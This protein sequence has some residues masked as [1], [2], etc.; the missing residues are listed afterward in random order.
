[1][2]FKMGFSFLKSKAIVMKDSEY[3][4]EQITN[5]VFLFFQ[6]M[7]PKDVELARVNFVK[8][9]GQFD[10]EHEYFELKLDDF[11]N[12]F[13]FFYGD[14]QFTNLKKIKKEKRF[15]KYYDYLLSGIFSIFLVQNIKGEEVTLK[16]IASNI[17]YKVKN[18]AVALSMEQGSCIQTSLY[19]QSGGLYEFGL[20][21]LVH[22]IRSLKYIKKKLKK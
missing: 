13:L 16:D 11:R 1:M 2:G 18:A 8:L 5:E 21:I 10:E 6:E 3:N 14:A 15:S 7:Y 4:L 17:I 22:P 19:Y 20:S 12:W 9:T